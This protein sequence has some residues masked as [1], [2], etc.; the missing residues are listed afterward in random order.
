LAQGGEEKKPGERAA[1]VCVDDVDKESS[2]QGSSHDGSSGE[3]NKMA[4]LLRVPRGSSGPGKK[5]GPK[6]ETSRVARGSG[7]TDA[8]SYDMGKSGPL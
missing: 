4:R 3:K 8:G 7:S 6:E 1:P 5:L 2:S